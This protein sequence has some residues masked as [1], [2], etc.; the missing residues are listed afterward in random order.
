MPLY[1]ASPR[2]RPGA[3]YSRYAIDCSLSPAATTCVRRPAGEPDVGLVFPA[4]CGISSSEIC[5]VAR[6]GVPSDLNIVYLALTDLRKPLNS[7]SGC[8][9]PHWNWIASGCGFFFWLIDLSVGLR[10]PSSVGRS[11]T[12]L[13]EP[14]QSSKNSSICTVCGWTP[15]NSGAVA[16]FAPLLVGRFQVAALLIE[17]SLG[18]K[19]KSS[20]DPSS[21]TS[22]AFGMCARSSYPAARNPL[23]AS[24]SVS[25]AIWLPPESSVGPVHLTGQTPVRFH[26]QTTSPLPSSTAISAPWRS[27][28]VTMPE[29]HFTTLAESLSSG[30][31]SFTF[32]YLRRPGRRWTWSFVPPSWYSK[33]SYSTERP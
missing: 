8:V 6:T 29:T 26:R 32:G 23:G 15:P 30:R 24:S 16:C 12:R 18:L 14:S 13:P 19:R 11:G 17:Y 22:D 2:H 9:P 10:Q 4:S 1:A 28:L 31:V 20:L 3:S 21:A 33:T 7:A 25:F 5:A 27:T